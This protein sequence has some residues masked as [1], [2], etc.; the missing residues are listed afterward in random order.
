MLGKTSK[1]FYL[2]LIGWS[3]L[4]PIGAFS[5]LKV[6]IVDAETNL[7]IPYVNIWVEGQHIGTTSDEEGLFQIEGISDTATLVFSCIAYQRLRQKKH[8]LGTI[9]KLQKQATQLSAVTVSPPKNE[10]HYKLGKIRKRKVKN[11]FA[12]GTMP[13]RIAKPIPFEEQFRKTPFLKEVNILTDSDVNG[14]KL[15][16][17]IL[18]WNKNDIEAPINVL[19]S[20]IYQEVKKGKKITRIDLENYQIRVPENGLLLLFEWLIIEQNKYEFEVRNWQTQ[21]MEQRTTYEPSI[22]LMPSKKSK[23]TYLYS[24]GQ[25]RVAEGHLNFKD[26]QLLEIAAELIFT[27]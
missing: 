26:K 19:Q 7:P 3:L 2:L 24:K 14:A 25:W 13:W 6:Q 27:D 5:Q 1:V 10:E 11:Y 22:G 16:I 21:V 17:D 4:I 9:I 23:I 20:A 12:C 18:E 15:R 8:T